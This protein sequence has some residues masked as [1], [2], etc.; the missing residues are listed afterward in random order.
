MKNS[1][2][3]TLV[4]F[5][6]LASLVM[7]ATGCHRGKKIKPRRRQRNLFSLEEDEN[8]QIIEFFSDCLSR[9]MSRRRKSIPTIV[10]FTVLD[11]KWFAEG[12]LLYCSRNKDTKDCWKNMITFLI[13]RKSEYYF[14]A[15]YCV[16]NYANKNLSGRGKRSIQSD[17]YTLL[18]IESNFKKFLTFIFENQNNDLYDLDDP[19]NDINL[20]TDFRLA[21]PFLLS[22]RT[23]TST[24]IPTSTFKTTT[25]PST[26]IKQ[27]F[28]AVEEKSKRINRVSQRNAQVSATLD[29]AA[30]DD[31]AD[32]T[33][34]YQCTKQT[35]RRTSRTQ[36]EQSEDELKSILSFV[37]EDFSRCSKNFG[38]PR[39]SREMKDRRCVV[40]S[41]GENQ[42]DG[43]CISNI[44]LDKIVIPSSPLMPILRTCKRANEPTSFAR[45]LNA[46]FPILQKFKAEFCN[47]TW[48]EWYNTFHPE[49]TTGDF[50]T[51]WKIRLLNIDDVCPTPTSIDI[52]FADGKP[53]EIVTDLLE[54]SK[55]GL[56]C[57]NS[58]QSDGICNDYAVRFCC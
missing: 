21:H 40:H 53:L 1:M 5:C 20:I 22:P 37:W 18:G 23:T 13:D 24:T 38:L 35:E 43:Q 10:K 36:L 25:M 2:R 32:F 16:K 58:R 4:I 48:T 52:R 8:R 51:L 9:V 12:D 55:N 7:L 31:C 57:E 54:I 33:K 28:A 26:T 14:P 49:G 29:E 44:I 27:T 50:E 34:Y 30:A 39:N 19:Y 56:C 46:T 42:M 47:G 17:F 41:H 3:T 15:R 6:I 11:T 45:A